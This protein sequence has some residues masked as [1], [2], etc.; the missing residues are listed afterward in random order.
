MPLAPFLRVWRFASAVPIALLA[1]PAFADATGMGA[2]MVLQAV[3]GLAVVLAIILGALWVL[4]RMGLAK[5]ASGQP[6]KVVGGV[7]VG[8]RERVML[9]EVSGQWLVVG[10][11]PGSVNLL[12]QMPARELPESS[13]AG[14]VPPA[15]ANWLKA[16]MDK[17]NAK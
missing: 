8:N 10:V 13:Q 1:G 9:V 6:L 7:S 17:R 2:G 3:F 16:T 12:S 5:P 15:F 4:K 14:P 11:A